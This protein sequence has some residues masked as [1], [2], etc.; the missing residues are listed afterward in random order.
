M[1]RKGIFAT[2]VVLAFLAPIASADIVMD[3][4]DNPGVATFYEAQENVTAYSFDTADKPD[5]SV[6]S[7]KMRH[8]NLAGNGWG[9]V[10]GQYSP[11]Y[12]LS[13]ETTIRFWAKASAPGVTLNV[14]LAVPNW[15]DGASWVTG[16]AITTNWAQYE[17]PKTS[18]VINPYYTTGVTPVDWANVGTFQF[19]V[20]GT[21]DTDV[22]IDR[23][24]AFGSVGVGIATLVPARSASV[25]TLPDVSVT[26]SKSVTG[27][28]AAD[29]T[30]NGSAATLVT[31]SGAGPYVF[32]G[33]APPAIGTANVALASGGITAG[34]DV[35]PGD[36]WTYQI[37]EW[38]VATAPLLVNPVTLDGVLNASEWSDAN[39]YYFDG[40]DNTTRPGWADPV[41]PAS[42]FACTF[43]V[44]HD[45]DFIY[46]GV[47][48]YDDIL[49][50]DGPDNPDWRDDRME[51]YFDPDNS[52]TVN[53]TPPADGPGGFQMTYDGRNYGG[54]YFAGFE[55]WWWAK[56][57]SDT[58]YVTT[59]EFR[60]AKQ[61][62]TT[63]TM[64]T[65]G[66]YGFDLSPCD[67]DTA[68]DVRDHQIWWNAQTGNAWNNEEPW[69]DIFLSPLP[70]EVPVP[71]APANLAATP[72]DTYVRLTWDEASGF[73]EYYRI[74]Q[75]ETQGGPYTLATTSTATIKNVTGLT[76]GTLYYFIV[77]AVNA[78]GESGPSNEVSATPQQ[79]LS[80]GARRWELYR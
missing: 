17:L 5:G 19:G 6:A 40:T 22:W 65:G 32:S 15:Q 44:K 45:V 30:V 74:K 72:A 63:V 11:A 16:V 50:A 69:G 77:T 47:Y 1:R 62:S 46:V 59:Y 29:L 80:L 28:D 60:V 35:F 79:G 36:T 3:H 53:I 18:F 55:D 12:D 70:K 26:F 37:E 57:T 25:P 21:F 27:V 54:A 64:V 49:I 4:F 48:V 68:G 39:H 66:T 42:D 43:S 38:M 8:Q 58:V 33:Y 56:A 71:G 13:A 76:N 2:V 41:L 75:S 78:A 73:P 9:Q 61:V 67:A 34:A 52:N 14:S 31:G 20:G 10:Q 23:F 7:L 51:M 24:E